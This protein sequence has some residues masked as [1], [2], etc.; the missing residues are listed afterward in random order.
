MNL[1][2]VLE[3]YRTCSFSERDKGARFERLIK[4]YLL[5]APVYKTVIEKVWLWNEFPCRKDFGSG[6]D[7]GIDLVAKTYSGDYWAI[8]CKC[9]REDAVIAKK[10]VDTFL[11]TSSRKFCDEELKPTYFSHRLWIDTTRKPWSSEAAQVIQSQM[12]PVMVLHADFLENESIDWEKLE[13]EAHPELA[14]S[15]ERTLLSHQAE[16]IAAFSDHFKT[17]S[18]GRLIMACGTGKTFTSLR[19]AEHE[20]NSNGTILFLVPSIALLAQTLNEWT[21][22]AEKPINAICVC[23]D[24]EVSRRKVT[25][26][27]DGDFGVQ[28]LALPATT[29]VSALVKQFQFFRQTKKTSGMT[30]VFSTYQSI[31]CVHQAQERLNQESPNSCIFDLVICDE[32]HRTTGVSLKK[33]DASGYDESHFVRVHDDEF[34]RAKKRLYM[35]ATPRLYNADAKEKAKGADVYLCS[36]DDETLYGKEVYRIG[37]GRAVE[38]GL[39]SDYKVLVLTMTDDVVSPGVQKA[40]AGSTDEISTDDEAK[41]IGC[42]NGLSKRLMKDAELIQSSDPG[43]MHTAVAFCSSIKVSKQIRDVFNRQQE[44][45]YDTLTPEEKKELVVV[46]ADHIDGSMGATLRQEKLDWLKKTPLNENKCRILTNVRCLSEGVDVPSLDAVMFLSRRNSQVDVVQSVGRVM[47]RAP[48]KKYGYII[49][50]V[51]IPSTASAEEALDNNDC[52]NVV[53][54][55][56]NALRSHDDRF[57]AEINKIDLNRRAGNAPAPNVI[58]TGGKGVTV[59]ESGHIISTVMSSPEV[60]R[61][62]EFNIKYDQL[63][64]AIYAKM[65]KKVGTRRY[66]ELWAEDI[67]A[68]AE[69]HI[70]RIKKLIASEGPHKKEFETFLTGLQKNLNPSV[71]AD[72]AIEMLSQHIITRPVFDALF[73]NDAFVK[74]NAVSL[75][76]QKMLKALDEQTPE[77]DVK[78]M[79][80]FTK[81][82]AERAAGITSAEGK[83][84]IIVELYDKFFKSAFPKVVEKLGIV[85]TPVEVVDF[86][87]E[88]VAAVLKKDFNRTLTEENVH[89]LDPFTGTGTFITRL[90]QS[91]HIKDEDLLRKYKNEIHANEIVLLAYYI[92]S[93][94][95]ENVFHDRSNTDY[96]PFT[97]ICLTDTFQLGEKSDGY[98]SEMFTKNSER[99]IEQMKAPIRIIIGNPPYSVG[100]KSANDNAQ[101]QK[102]EHLDS[103]IAATYVAAGTSTLKSQLYDSYIKA[104]RWSADRLDKEHGGI[105]AFVTNGSWL[106][107]NAMNGFRKCLADEFS[108]IYV[109]NLRGNQRTSGE[110][111]RR[112]GGKIFGSGSRTPVAVTILVK[113]PGE[114]MGKA[115]IL[116]RDIGDYLSREEKLL[117]IKKMHN[118][119]NPEMNLTAI[120]PDANNDWLN[121]RGG[122]FETFVPIQPEKK[123]DDSAQSVFMLNSCGAKSGRDVW[124][125]N[126][127]KCVLEN[128]MIAMIDFYNSCVERL[129]KEREKNKDLTAE[130]LMASDEIFFDPTKISWNRGLRNDFNKEKFFSFQSDCMKVALYRPFF[131]QNYY[132]DRNFNDMSSQMIRLFPTPQSENLVICVT[133]L[134]SS[135]D[136]SSIITDII[137]DVQLQSNAQCFP[138]YYYEKDVGAQ[139]KLALFDQESDHEGYVR[140][141]GVSDFILA[142]ARELNPKIKKENIFYYIYGLLHSIEYRKRFSADLK[143]M[144]P[145]IPLPDNYAAFKAF[146][147]AGRELADL[148]LHYET[149]QPWTGVT[150]V[151]KGTDLTVKKMRFA[152]EGKEKDRSTILLN[153]TCRIVGIPLRA[154]DYQVNGKSP[155]EWAMER[156]GVSCDKDSGIINDANKWGEEQNNPT[157]ILDLLPRLVTVSMK[158]LQ[159]VDTLP[160][161]NFS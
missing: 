20:T 32:A 60:M 34:I 39:L 146:E 105:V 128:N 154:Y 72:D 37:F 42:I 64:G 57:N 47:R 127:S 138:L 25:S 19:L 155:L 107:G 6:N 49:I 48:G 153:E 92:A 134:G 131:K 27:D 149:L 21:T 101:N 124:A 66:W 30:V 115:D 156:Y 82:V 137:P 160:K 56:L 1:H 161:L 103:R 77:R 41:I 17:F 43:V 58:G 111:S 14:I 151:Q 150:V 97:G 88:S 114:Q 157:Y 10:D 68:I 35:T 152:G 22:F 31:D 45:Y 93:V 8:Q 96:E 140:R 65:V 80:D 69:A 62:L 159:I 63:Q 18:R 119:L 126:S 104:F 36:M 100:Q 9:Y 85:Y 108:N 90:L 129:K 5:V 75:V 125:Y 95:I 46:E 29:N 16:A 87:L 86:I 99:V 91:A 74:N 78:I 44:A 23:S 28:N 106:D 79:S 61:Q 122:L 67:A 55:V 12:I 135:K 59:D 143:K 130:E 24:A 11:S 52:Y 147:K 109:F 116:Y 158:T 53:W 50:P 15:S 13:D 145:H 83:Q 136:F 70:E 51:V 40:L 141:D 76:L 3:K 54:T 73:A 120:T 71:T 33:L 118:I 98:F 110:L 142:R 132:I 84:K 112:E 2:R 113:K 133:G 89:I 123:L 26:G 117:T 148:H 7:A 94:N 102:Y 81:S 144:L 4:H 121:Q 139:A 38:L